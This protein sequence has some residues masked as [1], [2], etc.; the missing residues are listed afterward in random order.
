MSRIL[1]CWFKEQNPTFEVNFEESAK[2]VLDLVENDIEKV[3]Q[4]NLTLNENE[5]CLSIQWQFDELCIK[6]EFCLKKCDA[7]TVNI[8]RYCF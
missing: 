3:T 8:I 5:T 1:P 4:A 6:Y 2:Q 7:N